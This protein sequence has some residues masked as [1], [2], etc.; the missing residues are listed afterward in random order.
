MSEKTSSVVATFEDGT[1]TTVAQP[2]HICDWTCFEHGITGVVW[3]S[4]DMDEDTFDYPQC[5][6]DALAVEA[7]DAD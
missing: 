2:G 1:M 3:H 4:I 7:S 6:L 5:V